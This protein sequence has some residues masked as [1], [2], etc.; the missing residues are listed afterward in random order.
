[1]LRSPAEKKPDHGSGSASLVGKAKA[2]NDQGR[3]ILALAGREAGETWSWARMAEGICPL[4]EEK[5]C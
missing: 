4:A 1:M 5:A 3:G 2:A